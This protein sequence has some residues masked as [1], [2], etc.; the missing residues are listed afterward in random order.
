MSDRPPKTFA[1]LSGASFLMAVSAIGPGFLTQTT[2]F[3][4]QLGA[5]LAFVIL[6]STL[7]DIGAQTNTWL[8]LGVSRKRG[9]E[10]ASM[11]VPGLGWLVLGVIVLGSFIF[12]IGNLAG[13]A[14]G[15][16]V[17]FDLPPMAGAAISAVIALGLFLLPQMRTGVDWF[18]KLLG[19]GMIL[20]TLVIVFQTAPP[21]GT[22]AVQA[23]WP[24]K[25]DITAL[26]TLIGGTIGGYIMFSG[27]H[28]L[29]DGGMG[30]KEH[31]PQIAKAAAWG[32]V[33]T[34]LMRSLLFLAV[35]GVVT[36]GQKL[37]GNLIVFDAF[38]YGAGSFGTIVAGLVFWAAA[39]TSVVGCTYTSITFLAPNAPAKIQARWHT[40][41]LALGLAATLAVMWYGWQPR[42]VLIAAGTINGILL[43]VFLGVIL[44]AARQRRILGDYHIPLWLQIAGWLAWL[45][46]VYIAYHEVATRV[47]QW[48]AA[49]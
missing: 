42:P 10:V 34:G 15:L 11:V 48:Q 23:V 3:T 4:A 32:I 36:A 19:A 7:I 25:I 22:A 43:P 35:L 18:S 33:I 49:G 1:I 9:H 21:V 47:K 8:V 14:Q 45:A 46:T 16:E 12:N 6:A 38:R 2:Q 5:S 24:D 31:A 17:L 27:A 28:R 26:V 37:E 39:I 40:G 20:L 44:L 29:L 13:C 41:F 30:G